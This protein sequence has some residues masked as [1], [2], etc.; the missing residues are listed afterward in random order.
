M[1]FELKD[2]ELQITLLMP[3]QKKLQ[4][5][6]DISSS[7]EVIKPISWPLFDAAIDAS[8]GLKQLLRLCCKQ[9]VESEQPLLAGLTDEPNDKEIK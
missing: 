3:E 5:A 8:A 4:D 6:L 9:P 2:G 1:K 7:I